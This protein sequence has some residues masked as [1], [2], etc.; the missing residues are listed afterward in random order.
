MTGTPPSLAAPTPPSWAKKW[1]IAAGIYNLVWGA[2]VVLFPLVWFD[3]A[4]MEAPRYP[5]LWQCVGMIVGVYGIGYLAAARDPWRHWP[6][7]LVGLLGKIFGPIG[8]V[9]A[10]AEGAFPPAFGLTILTNDLLWWIP[11]S[12]M[13]WGAAKS[14][15]A[16]IGD[17]LP[18]STALDGAADQ[19]GR[20]VR[21]ISDERPTLALLV[22][23]SGCTFCKEA[24]ADLSNQREAIER[25]GMAIVVVSM[26][27]PES[28]A[29]AAST[30]GLGDVH[31]VS[32]PQRDLY[33]ALELG[34]GSFKQL[35]GPS[36]WWRG[37][38]ATMR[39]HLG[40]GLDGDGVQMP[41]AFVR[42]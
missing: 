6:I 38:M 8:F 12:M 15:Y 37:M 21:E 41:G 13:L 29:R 27:D 10:V 16:L 9:Q 7:V 20:S 22:R 19:H 33:Q 11:F 17:A 30:A 5:Q 1:L 14:Q 18:L 34:R 35:F 3:V 42:H 28:L 25:E 32:D 23:H 39:G 40:G 31:L 2:L 24:L 26:S 4:G 36:V